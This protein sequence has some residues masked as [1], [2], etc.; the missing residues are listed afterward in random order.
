MGEALQIDIR[1]P[2]RREPR[3]TEVA[4]TKHLVTP[5]EVITR[6]T[7]YMRGHGTFTADNALVATTAGVV[8]KFNKLIVVRPMKSR[9]NGEVGDVIVGRI[10]EVAQRR[11]KVDTNGRLDA[12]LMLSAVNLPGNVLRRRQAEDEFLMRE[13]FVENDVIAAEVQ[14]LNQDGSLNLHRVKFGQKLQYGVFVKVHSALVRR[15]KTQSHTLPC[16]VMVILGNNGYT[17]I[18]PPQEDMTEESG[19]DENL[20]A[21]AEAITREMRLN[22][23]RVRNAICALNAQF[24]SIF[25]TSVVYTYEASLSHPVADMLKPE[26]M[27]DIT[28][29]ARLLA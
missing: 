18:G 15:T 24:V 26:V 21:A 10:T 9:Y 29:E 1:L 23:A 22:I 4:A 12:S 13:L 2:V 6:D 11:W 14:S 28:Q 7:G 8:D 16:G 3:S 25:D 27:E 5:G 17:W 19:Q 20:K